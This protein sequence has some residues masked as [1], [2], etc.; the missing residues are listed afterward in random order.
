MKR[1]EGNINALLPV[2]I[3][4]LTFS[5]GRYVLINITKSSINNKSDGESHFLSTGPF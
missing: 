1:L 5:D 4:K 3:R 2:G